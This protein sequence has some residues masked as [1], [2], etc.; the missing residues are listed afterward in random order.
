MSDY[1]EPERR[2]LAHML[3][4]RRQEGTGRTRRVTLDEI[5]AQSM[6]N[7]GAMYGKTYVHGFGKSRPFPSDDVIECTEYRELPPEQLLLPPGEIDDQ[8]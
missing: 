1:A 3:N 4:V 8:E 6:D 7:F 5:L 2:T